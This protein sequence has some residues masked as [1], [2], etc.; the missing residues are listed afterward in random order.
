MTGTLYE[1]FFWIKELILCHSSPTYL[2]EKVDDMSHETISSVEYD[3]SITERRA[4]EDLRSI[5]QLKRFLE[6]LT[7]DSKFREKI[8]AN[9]ASADNLAKK[10]GIDIDLSKFSGKF[11]PSGFIEV[12]CHDLKE[13][14]LAVLWREWIQDWRTFV[15]LIREDGYS[16]SADPRFNAWRKRQ[17]ERVNIEFGAAQAD[18]I[19]HPIFSFE[20]SK[21]CSVG[22]WFCALGAESFRGYYQRTPKNVLLWR[23]VLSTAVDL[24]GSAVQTGACYWATEPFDNPNYLDFIQ[25]YL[26]IVGIVPQTTSAAPMRDLVWTRRLMEMHKL[27]PSVPSRF[28]IVNSRILR[29]LHANFSPEELLCYE[30]IMQLKGSSY[31]KARAGKTL[32]KKLSAESPRHKGLQIYEEV[33]S[34]ACMSGYLVNMM[35][36]IIQLVSP[37]LANERWPLGYRVHASGTFSTANEFGDFIERSISEH[38]PAGLPPDQAV[39][40]RDGLVYESCENGF[41]LSSDFAAHSF[42]GFGFVSKLGDMVAEGKYKPAQIIGD[43]VD[44]GADIFGVR[45]T[46]EDLFNKGF[47]EDLPI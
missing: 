34:I 5:A 39:A 26:D 9:P 15:K 38:M 37:S 31:G 17:V 21:G 2:Q 19:S 7:G 20:L 43:L 18:S 13:Y 11:E 40:Y 28:S 16:H 33:G 8:K 12:K 41:L 22:C 3:K 32:R 4:A 44:E 45:G 36:G 27:Y 14:P 30:L 10:S 6:C 47:L 24:F 46:L 25:D 42:T 1:A 29:D 35:D 23:N